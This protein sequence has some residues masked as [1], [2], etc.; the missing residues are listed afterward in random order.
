MAQK[1]L[2]I[3]NHKGGVGKTT[4]AVTLAHG[5]ARRGKETLLL[6]LDPQGQAASFLGINP[7]MDIFYLL[8]AGLNGQPAEH[9]LVGLRQR[10]RSSGRPHL[11]IV[12][13]GSETAAGQQTIGALA[14]PISFLLD[15][16]KP[17]IREQFEYVVIDTSPSLGGL[18][19]RAI[20][21]SDFVIS[22]VATEFAALEGLGQLAQKTLRHLKVDLAWRGTLLGVLPTFFDET[23]RES[24]LSMENLRASFPNL[25]LAPVHRATTLRECA[26][27]GLTIFETNP[28]QRDAS[29]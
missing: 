6:D 26:A 4:T 22:P 28:D 17:L 29:E 21:A 12:P 16:I 2:S 11:W 23:T 7:S 13:G 19:E 27:E 3:V 8:I 25:L 10:I 15:T 20:W 14:K 9:E 18:Q 24:R 1:I 5:L